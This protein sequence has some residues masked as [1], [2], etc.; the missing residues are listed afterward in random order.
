[1]YR[2]KAG[3]ERRA[4]TREER[5]FAR[6]DLLFKD[7][8]V[9]VRTHFIIEMTWWTGLAPRGGRTFSSKTSR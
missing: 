3:G 1:M 7:L 5:A 6:K 9:L 4:I 8:E 2:L